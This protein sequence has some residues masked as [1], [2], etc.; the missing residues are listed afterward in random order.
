MRFFA[1]LPRFGNTS[2]RR[3]R[4]LR[5]GVRDQPQNL[6]DHLSQ[7]G[8]FDYLEGDV[9][10][11]ADARSPMAYRSK[12][13]ESSHFCIENRCFA[14]SEFGR[15]DIIISEDLILSFR[16]CS[17][18][19]SESRPR[20][21]RA[22]F[23]KLEA[24]IDTGSVEAGR[25]ELFLCEVCCSAHVCNWHIGWICCSAELSLLSEHKRT[26]FPQFEYFSP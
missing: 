16:K 22:G 17:R 24:C 19:L 18:S 26:G 6:L 13:C 3:R 20:C 4:R 12:L 7:D 5:P 15:L 9:V 21:S 25:G 10:S 2:C 1:S 8:E 23:K 11:V 14:E